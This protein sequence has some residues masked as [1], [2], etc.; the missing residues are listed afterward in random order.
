MKR[1]HIKQRKTKRTPVAQQVIDDFRDEWSNKPCPLCGGYQRQYEIH[2]IVKRRGKV[3]DDRRNLLPTCWL[4]HERIHTGDQRTMGGAILRAWTD[5]DVE[6][7]KRRHDP[8]HYD[9]AYLDYLRNWERH[10]RETGR[11]EY[12]E[13]DDV[14]TDL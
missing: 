11:T 3:Y 10:Y 8:D 12:Q 6:R 2:H 7:A 5:E 9:P 1:S 4:C 14:S 13:N